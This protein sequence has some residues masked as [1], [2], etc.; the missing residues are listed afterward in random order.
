[1][2]N[3]NFGSLSIFSFQMSHF[4]HGLLL[5]Q[6]LAYRGKWRVHKCAYHCCWRKPNKP[7]LFSSSS[8]LFTP[9]CHSRSTKHSSL[10]ADQKPHT[11]VLLKEV[12]QYMDIKPGQVRNFCFLICSIFF[13]FKYIRRI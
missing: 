3:L 1:M 6:L 13:F 5:P 10:Q 4:W 8:S 11:P 7:Q 9:D 12:L 2:I